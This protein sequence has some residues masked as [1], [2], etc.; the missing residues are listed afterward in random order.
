MATSQ[1]VLRRWIAIAAF[2][3]AAMAPS[4]QASPFTF[5]T[6]AGAHDGD[7]NLSATVTF[8]FSGT[9]LYVTMTNNQA[10]PGAAG[11][12][13]SDLSFVLSGGVD[14][15]SLS[16]NISSMVGTSTPVTELDD[17]FNPT[18]VTT[19]PNGSKGVPSWQLTTQDTSST[20]CSQNL[21]SCY[22]L[23]DL[24]G[25]SPENMIIGPGPYGNNPSITGHAPSLLGPVVFEIDNVVGL[26]SGTTVS[27]VY[28]SFGTRPDFTS[29][30]TIVQM[31]PPPQG[32]PEPFSMLLVGAGLL[33]LGIYR[34]RRV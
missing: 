26:S 30:L 12:L 21:V 34:H 17:N 11:Q 4:A 16:N 23:N 24:T 13:L 6:A 5:T 29:P 22:F 32:V 15:G 20:D 10:N 33:G 8:T 2:T 28:L 1:G 27:N 18:S 19:I 3:L 7:G 14:A 25:G 9:T 31:D